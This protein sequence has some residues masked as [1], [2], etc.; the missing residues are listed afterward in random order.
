M[1][2][3]TDALTKVRP[4][5]FVRQLQLYLVLVTLT[6]VTYFL[7]SPYLGQEKTDMGDE[8]SLAVGNVSPETII[9]NKEII[10]DDLDKTKLKRAQALKQGR[11]AHSGVAVLYSPQCALWYRS[12]W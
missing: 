2:N 4:I 6:M 8:S 5:H 7:A 10:Y 3:T 1:A 9:S 12:G 11:Y